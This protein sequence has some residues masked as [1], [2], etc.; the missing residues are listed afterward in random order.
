M[1]VAKGQLIA[2]TSGEYSDYCLD[3]HMRAVRDFDSDE[4]FA[5][6]KALR[7]RKPDFAAWSIREG[8]MTPC[9][10]MEVLELWVGGYGEDEPSLREIPFVE[11]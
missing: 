11:Q 10:A 7:G 8:Y 9:E 4:M 1:K 5:A 6:Y 2:L 3:G